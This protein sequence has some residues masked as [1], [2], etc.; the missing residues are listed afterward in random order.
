LP[1]WRAAVLARDRWRCRWCGSAVH[2][3]VHHVR[4]MSRWPGLVL[5]LD[6]GLTLCWDCHFYEAH[7]GHPH[8]VHGLFAR[9]R[10]PLPGQLELFARWPG[11][12]FG[13]RS[14][15]SGQLS[16]PPSGSVWP[17]PQRLLFA[18]EMGD[19]AGVR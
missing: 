9:S 10:R 7:H 11:P 13:K 15:F 16:A 5:D 1:A 19:F 14:A 3:C 8:F 18:L 4:E 6:N 12:L 2:L 17:G